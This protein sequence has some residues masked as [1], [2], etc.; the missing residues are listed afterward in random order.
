[1]NSLS[2]LTDVG[3][4]PSIGANI[5]KARKALKMTQD[6]LAEA[7][8]ANRVTISQY[9][10]KGYDPSAQALKRL[11]AALH[12]TVEEL[13]ANDPIRKEEGPDTGAPVGNLERMIKDF[14]RLSPADQQRVLDFAAGIIS[15]REQ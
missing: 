6:E 7:I 12:T 13:V 8:G 2:K 4:E 10:N 15:A 14:S 5:R 1:M 3:F 9:E 11:A